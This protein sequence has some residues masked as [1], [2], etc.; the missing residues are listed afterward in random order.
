MSACL[1]QPMKVGSKANASAA[2]PAKRKNPDVT[3]ASAISAATSSKKQKPDLTCTVCGVTATSMKAMQDHLKGKGHRKKAAAL[4]QPMPEAEHEQKQKQEEEEGVV[5]PPSGGYTPS[6][7]TMLTN[8]GAMN[9]VL[10]M[11]GYL[12][13]EVCNVR[14]ADRVTMMCHL[15]GNKHTSKAQKPRQA[16]KPPAVSAAAA[17]K[18]CVK[19]HSTP[20]ITAAVAGDDPEAAVVAVDGVPR[21]VRRVDGFLL[22]E[23]C[24]VK[25]PSESVMQSHL[26]GKKHKNKAKISLEQAKVKDVASITGAAQMEVASAT[27]QAKAVDASLSVALKLA[28]GTAEVGEVTAMAAK[29]GDQGELKETGEMAEEDVATNVD[30]PTTPGQEVKKL[31]APAAAFTD[32]VN[33]GGSESVVVGVDGVQHGV[34][35]VD[36]FLLCACCN[37]KAP[38]DRIMRSHL[39]GKKHKNKVKV[40]AVHVG[41]GGKEAALAEA[42]SKEASVVAGTGHT[43]GNDSV[44]GQATGEVELAPLAT[45]QGHAACAG[46][47]MAP[48]EVDELAEVKGVTSIAEGDSAAAEV[49]S[50]ATPAQEVKIQVE[51]EMCTVLRQANGTLSCERC[52]VH[53]HDKNGML[54]HLYTRAHWD[55]VRV[56]E[57]KEQVAAAPAVVNKDSDGGATEG[58]AQVEN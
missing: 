7:L 17:V 4:A 11:D 47:S 34:Q 18:K 40:A 37:V 54:L 39:T 46:L 13:C 33:F 30:I 22:C 48:M 52:D 6:K 14:T 53:G 36:G 5:T 42:K 25:A 50:S 28:D 3:A 57:E 8:A 9:E 38:S 51:G 26:A 44:N 20:A 23:C 43:Q 27:L 15:E 29:V 58:T 31:D 24:D 49:N 32:T 21:T 56:D 19:G 10:Q 1:M 12:L 55:N 45:P 41:A 16:G 35:R 2:L